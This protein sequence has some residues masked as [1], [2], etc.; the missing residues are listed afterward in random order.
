MPPVPAP[1]RWK[2]PAKRMSHRAPLG[3]SILLREACP[4]RTYTLYCTLRMPYPELVLGTPVEVPDSAGE[5]VAIVARLEAI[6][7]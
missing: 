2:K 4:H 1:P 3:L 7:L 5:L 6:S